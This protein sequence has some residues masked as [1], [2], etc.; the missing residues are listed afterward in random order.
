MP[1]KI[2][3]ADDHP[4]FRQ[5]LKNALQECTFEKEV[6][7]VSDGIETLDFFK[8]QFADV[9][10]MDI[11][12][13]RLNGIE[14]SVQLRTSHPEV[15]IIALSSF[16]DKWHIEQMMEAGA[17]GYLLKN[18]TRPELELAILSV[19]Q[20]KMFFSPEL[21]GKM[22]HRS[23]EF[24]QKEARLGFEDLHE[25]EKNIIKLI[26]EEYNSAEIAAKLHLSEHTINSYRKSLLAK[27]GSKNVVGLIKFA[28]KNGWF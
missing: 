1:I 18:V 26:Y 10:L 23:A 27:T 3:I 19:Y 13:P 11:N 7:E 2:L 5:G 4:M 8:G 24:M 6:H 12:M 28:F 16:E 20:G 25:R 14:C 21:V 15:K 17:K 9:V 22:L